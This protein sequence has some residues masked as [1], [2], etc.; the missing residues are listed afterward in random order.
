MKKIKIPHIKLPTIKLK[1][2]KFKKLKISR[3]Q[4]VTLVAIVAIGA[5]SIL[6][7]KSPF[8]NNWEDVLPASNIFGDSTT[9][10]SEDDKYTAFFFEV[11]D[12]IMNHHWNQLSDEQLANITKLA[13]QKVSEQE[14]ENT[15]LTKNDLR[16]MLFNMME[17]K[18]DDEKKEF[19]TKVA[20]IV[21]ANLE[22]FGR[23]RLY[24]SQKQQALSNTVKNVDPNVDHYGAL[25]V[26]KE[27]TPEQVADAYTSKI[28]ELN[29]QEQTPEVEKEKA[30]VERAKEVLGDTGNKDVYDDSGAN[31]T[32]D[33]RLISPRI[34]YIHITKFSPTTVEEL[35]RVMQKY[36]SGEELDTL[37]ID[38]RG[39]IG[40]AI[41]GL[42]YFLGPFIGQNQYAYQFFKRGEKQDFITKTGWLPSLVRYKKVIVL[43]D[44]QVQS[45]GEVFASVLKKYNVGVL[46][47]VPTKGWGTVEAVFKIGNQVDPE[48]ETYSALLV[49]SLTLREDSI[50]IEGKG[51]DPTIN[52]TDPN[53]QQELYKYYSNQEIVNAVASLVN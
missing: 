34:A 7:R 24:T 15:P 8:G 27:A 45:S 33:N 44:E 30:N 49:H 35:D 25:G 14:L 39:N 4:L 53:W 37:I 41:D 26:D 20:D 11:Y 1:P 36:N 48:N 5:I 13:V 50:P 47:G 51:V 16:T 19:I 46:V 29:Q 22:P 3:R 23:S 43:I 32:I 10:E 21:L 17:G 18:S 42:P 6:G 9:E 12:L 31:P 2:I 38:L 40:G 52:I 28:Q